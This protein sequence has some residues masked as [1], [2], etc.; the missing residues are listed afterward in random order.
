M[1]EH[2]NAAIYGKTIAELY[3]SGKLQ[4]E[5]AGV[6][7]PAFDC[8]CII[9]KVFL[10]SR[11]DLIA[12]GDAPASPEDTDEFTELINRRLNYEPLQYILGQW[13]FMGYPFKVGRGVLIPREDTSEV[14]NL[15]ADSARGIENP[16]V[17]DL[18][19]GSG[20]IAVVLSKIL[21]NSSV[22]AVEAS[23]EAFCYLEENI[24]LNNA[25]VNAVKGDVFT[26]ADDFDDCSFD[27]ILSNP[28]YVSSGE[29]DDLQ[30]EVKAEPIMALDGGSDGCD[31][32]RFITANWKT[33]LKPGGLMAFELGENQ[34]EYVKGLMLKNGFINI[35]EKLDLG[36]IQRAIIGTLLKI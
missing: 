35:R 6:D 4:L 2:P 20:A 22:T 15:C 32:Y 19:S 27:I 11:A 8:M 12:R 28:P 29:I 36:G 9:E 5:R 34:F 23:A 7:S 30:K 26:C 10:F 31:F 14:V 33:K 21:K 16:A 13:S 25:A 18:C 1:T 3:Q 24:R 17:L